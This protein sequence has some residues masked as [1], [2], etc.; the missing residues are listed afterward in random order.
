VPFIGGVVSFVLVLSG[1]GGI[2]LAIF[3]K[4]GPP[5]SFAYATDGPMTGVSPNDEDTG[6]YTD[7]EN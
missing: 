2:V 5:V 4:G 7:R 6:N 3:R 1:L